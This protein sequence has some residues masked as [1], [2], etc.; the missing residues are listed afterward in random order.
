MNFNAR[1][2]IGVVSV[3]GVFACSGRNLD[4]GSNDGDSGGSGGTGFTSVGGGAGQGSGETAGSESGGT[5]SAGAPSTAGTSGSSSVPPEVPPLLPWPE[6]S[7]CQAS[8]PSETNPMAGVWHG[9]VQGEDT[10]FT[11]FFGEGPEG[12]C[13]TITWGEP[14]TL[15]P[16]TDPDA[17]YL[18]AGIN[19][20]NPFRVD[21]FAYTLFDI[22]L[23][24]P[25]LRFTSSLAQPYESWCAL[26]TPVWVPDLS[27]YS[28][29]PNVSARVAGDHCYMLDGTEVN[30]VRLGTCNTVSP[31]CACDAEQCQAS[32]E[33]LG[34]QLDLRLDG[35]SASGNGA[36]IFMDRE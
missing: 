8:E 29:G 19:Y 26:Q 24:G 5:E 16:A 28:C 3:V 12:P 34:D 33:V 23:D 14:Q 4:V 10:P 25:R 20:K 35:D 13:G 31:P 11:V 2:V 7:A 22:R 17:E 1:V 30:C 36:T 15:E 6:P 9:Y 27:Q 21:G 32:F 18:E